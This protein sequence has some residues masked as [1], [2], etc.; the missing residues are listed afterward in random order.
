MA[1][2][3]DDYFTP[4]IQEILAQRAMGYAVRD[5]TP[6]DPPGYPNRD[7][8]ASYEAARREREYLRRSSEGP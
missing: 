4:E 3:P 5:P 1:S 6:P 7:T 2:G 8:A